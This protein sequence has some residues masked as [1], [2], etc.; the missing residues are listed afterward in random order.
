ML[1]IE[2][3]FLLKEVPHVEYDDI[4]NIS[5]YYIREDNIW[6]RFRKIESKM[7][8]DIKYIKTIKKTVKP[9]VSDEEEWDLDKETYEAMVKKCF[10]ALSESR[11]IKKTRHI[12]KFQIEG[13][14]LKWEIDEF[15][16]ISLVMAEVEIP[17]EDFFV[18][19]PNWMIG[20][21][22]MEVSNFKEFSNRRLAR[23]I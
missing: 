10:S 14:D 5:Q 17:E 19:L 22:I 8:S 1:E 23:R 3:K 6:V 18:Y 4:L 7:T 21:K 2:R 11:Y 9:G 16:D 20:Y 12:K 13:I 15:S